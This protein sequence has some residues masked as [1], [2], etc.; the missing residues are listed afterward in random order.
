MMLFGMLLAIVLYEVRDGA[1]LI[2][3]SRSIASPYVRDL[4]GAGKFEPIVGGPPIQLG[5]QVHV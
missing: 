4:L 5:L 1:P 2:L 3:N